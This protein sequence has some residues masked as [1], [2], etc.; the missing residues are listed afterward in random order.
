MKVP[1]DWPHASFSHFAEAAQ[2]NWHIQSMGDG[3]GILL[4][5]GTGASTH[6]WRDVMPLLATTYRV[7]AIDLPGH[8]FTSPAPASGR[9]L[10]GMVNGITALLNTL[11]LKPTIVVGNSAGAA[12]LA[13]M[14]AMQHFH[15]DR[16]VSFNGAFFPISGIAGAMFSPIAKTIAALPFMPKL[17]ASMADTSAVARLMADTGSRLS[18]EGID[19][20][21]RLFRSST[22]IEATLGMMAAWDLSAMQQDLS[23]LQTP[24]TF[25]AAQNDKTIPPDI[26][27]KAAKLCPHAQVVTVAQYGHLM[28]EEAP[29]KAA[30]IIRNSHL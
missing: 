23:R 21:R 4:V 28:H 1:T 26:A 15:P 27:H 22:H 7:H 30:D 3:P 13:R 17:F 5:H 11:N 29:E 2:V 25:V 20:Y 9:S 14:C 8:G 18:P 19:L 16:F 24:A 12:I 10:D 6:S